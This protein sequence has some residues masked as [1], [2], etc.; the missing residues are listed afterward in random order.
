MLEEIE[1]KRRGA[2]EDEMV[3]QHHKLNGHE[4]EQTLGDSG[5]ERSLVLQSMGGK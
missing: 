5:G 1:S 3:R 2:A 4:S